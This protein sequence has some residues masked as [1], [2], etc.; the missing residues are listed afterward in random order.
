ML[1]LDLPPVYASAV[2]LP[3]G[4]AIFFA[5]LFVLLPSAVITAVMGRMVARRKTNYPQFE[6]EIIRLLR[7]ASMVAA[8]ASL[9]LAGKVLLV[10]SG[11]FSSIPKGYSEGENIS[12][13]Y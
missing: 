9:V 8:I 2:N 11:N 3:G 1:L 4:G 6:K 12:D 13:P 7:G 5:G 10:A